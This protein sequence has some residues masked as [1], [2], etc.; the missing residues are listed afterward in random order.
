MEI[1]QTTSAWVLPPPPVTFCSQAQPPHLLRCC[2][3][4][5]AMEV[6]AMAE[7]TGENC[8][9]GAKGQ[10]VL[11]NLNLGST[12]AAFG[13]RAANS[14]NGQRVFNSIGLDQAAQCYKA[15]WE[16]S[17]LPRGGGELGNIHYKTFESSLIY[18][19][20]APM[21][22][23]PA[24]LYAHTRGLFQQLFLVSTGLQ[25]AKCSQALLFM[26]LSQTPLKTYISFNFSFFSFFLKQFLQVL[27]TNGNLNK[28]P[29]SQRCRGKGEHSQPDQ[30]LRLQNIF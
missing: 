6:S 10:L 14:S 15:T 26:E 5:W 8:P 11:L 1:C 18:D 3:E 4:G 24:R 2:Y 19:H 12:C 29:N 17:P 20:F 23:E 21:S 22:W 27:E 16:H 28:P 25:A 13:S 9:G 7:S 30:D